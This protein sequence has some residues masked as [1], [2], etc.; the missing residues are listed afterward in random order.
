MNQIKLF[1][2]DLLFF[3]LNA[4]IF[5]LFFLT[6]SDSVPVQIWQSFVKIWWKKDLIT[7][8]I[9]DINCLYLKYINCYSS[10]SLSIRFCNITQIRHSFVKI[11]LEKDMTSCKRTDSHDSVSEKSKSLCISY[12]VAFHIIWCPILFHQ[13]F[14]QPKRDPMLKF[15]NSINP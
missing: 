7:G 12:F 1:H 5:F 3:T 14:F 15:Y 4:S 2:K 11:W 9:L 13:H 10:Y 8:Y 6:W